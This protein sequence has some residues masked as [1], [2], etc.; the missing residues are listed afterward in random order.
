MGTHNSWDQEVRRIFLFTFPS[1]LSLEV[2]GLLKQAVDIPVRIGW[3]RDLKRKEG[4][5]ELHSKAFRVK[6][7]TGKALVHHVQAHYHLS[8]PRHLEPFSVPPLS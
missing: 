7:H 3:R 4:N 8:N 1:L 2:F 5:E 6:G